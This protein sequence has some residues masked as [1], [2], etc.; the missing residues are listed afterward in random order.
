MGLLKLLAPLEGG[1]VC[2]T[3]AGG[4]TS[5]MYRL[6]EEI[7]RAGSTAI[8]TTTEQM[9]PPP[10]G[11]YSVIEDEISNIERPANIPFMVA[12]R[13]DSGNSRRYLGYSAEE[14]DILSKQGQAD[15]ILVEVGPSRGRYVLA[16]DQDMI[17]YPRGTSLVIGMVGLSAIN[18]DLESVWV[19]GVENFSKVSGLQAAARI[20]EAALAKLATDAN[21][22]FRNVPAEARKMLFLN[23]ADTSAT[24]ASGQAIAELVLSGCSG[25]YIE[26]VC[27][28]AALSGA[29]VVY[30]YHK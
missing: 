7:E 3:G 8:C 16:P 18:H 6:A 25:E 12:G 13:K 17:K 1:I 29:G 15:W 2:F 24:R 14:I 23:Q 21:G 20:T 10:P 27:I 5:L 30:E 4:K 26:G 28:G 22:V 9:L 19:Q 11:Y